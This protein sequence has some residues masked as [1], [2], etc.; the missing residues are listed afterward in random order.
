MYMYMDVNRQT[1]I[2]GA[3][4]LCVGG[5][6]GGWMGGCLGVCVCVCACVC[7]Y[8]YEYVSELTNSHRWC[9]L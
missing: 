2:A 6:V 9:G 1:L 5:W 8:G 4:C 3:L 7:V